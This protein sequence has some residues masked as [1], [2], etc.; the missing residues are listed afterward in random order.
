MRRCCF[1]VRGLIFKM[2]RTISLLLHPCN[3]Q[4]QHLLVTG[5]Y[6][7]FIEVNH[8]LF[9]CSFSSVLG[10]RPA[11]NRSKLF[12]KSSLVNNAI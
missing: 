7:D 4:T 12:A 8:G 2:A 3:E 9:V 10:S 5:S 11:R 6:L 1:T